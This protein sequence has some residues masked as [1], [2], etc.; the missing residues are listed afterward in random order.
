MNIL[1]RERNGKEEIYYS[2]EY[3]KRQ[4]ELSYKAGLHKGIK[5]Q[6]HAVTPMDGRAVDNLVSEFKRRLD[7]EYQ[8]S[9][10][11]SEVYRV[12]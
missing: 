3:L 12:F 5:V 1:I 4:I 9:F 11:N 10:S 2:D 7:E 6:F 8:I